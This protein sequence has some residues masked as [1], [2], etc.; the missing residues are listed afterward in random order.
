[1]MSESARSWLCRERLPYRNNVVNAE[2]IWIG[3]ITYILKNRL[4]WLE[5][6]H[7]K[8]KTIRCFVFFENELY[9][10]FI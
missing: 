6:R 3:P 1:M 2:Q 8:S 5:N 7:Y 10:D 9:P 4:S